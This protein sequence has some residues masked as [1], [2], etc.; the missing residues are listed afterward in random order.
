MR[1][2]RR[3][4]RRLKEVLRVCC[5]NGMAACLGTGVLGFDQQVSLAGPDHSVANV[6]STTLMINVQFDF[7][8]RKTLFD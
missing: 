4:G 5:F 7:L 8:E 6:S 3:V 1:T 2:M